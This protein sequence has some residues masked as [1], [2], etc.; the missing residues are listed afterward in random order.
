MCDQLTENKFQAILECKCPRCRSGKMFTH[1]VYN[2]KK[3]QKMFRRC[4]VC[5]L[6]F[7]V[8]PGFFWGAMYVSYFMSVGYAI[9]SALMVYVLFNDP[10][11]MAYIATIVSLIIFLSPFSYRYSR[12]FMIYWIS[13]IRFDRSLANTKKK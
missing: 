10:S 5:D 6:E 8:E 9:C 7:E 3:F 4:P 13:P 1:P 2:L 11:A 12:V